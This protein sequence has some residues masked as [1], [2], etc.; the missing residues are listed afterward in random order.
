MHDLKRILELTAFFRVP[1]GVIINK[2]DLN[3]EMTQ[4]IRAVAEQQ[5]AAVLGELPYDGTFN[6]AQLGG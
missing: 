2:A 3:D 4:S 5:N 1:A 6:N